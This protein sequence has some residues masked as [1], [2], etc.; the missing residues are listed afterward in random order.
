MKI[1][2]VFEK[3]T[4]ELPDLKVDDELMVGKFKNRKATITGFKKDKH[5]QPVAK[6]DKGDQAIF[7]PRVKK[8]M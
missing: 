5:N 6:T 7:K 3:E 4:L 8:L 2:D 1:S